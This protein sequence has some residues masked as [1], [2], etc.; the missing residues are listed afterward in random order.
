MGGWLGG[1]AK[2]ILFPTGR[3]G[4]WVVLDHPY[5]RKKGHLKVNLTRNHSLSQLPL[6]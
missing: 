1:I 2:Y 5:I 6:K 4:R 3:R